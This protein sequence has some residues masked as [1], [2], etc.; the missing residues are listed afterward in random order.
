MRHRVRVQCIYVLPPD[1]N[2]IID[3]SITFD[4]ISQYREDSKSSRLAILKSLTMNA[5]YNYCFVLQE[6]CQSSVLA[7]P[8]PAPFLGFGKYTVLS[9]LTLTFKSFFIQEEVHG[10]DHFEFDLF[11]K[12]QSHLFLSMLLQTTK[13][14]MFFFFLKIVLLYIYTTIFVIL[15]H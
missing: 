13:L 5:T 11:L 15:T 7:P 3:M 10:A 6:S 2:M 14:H 4:I 8:S 1:M 9:I 12:P